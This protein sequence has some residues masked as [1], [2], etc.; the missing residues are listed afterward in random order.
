MTTMHPPDLA[1][2]EEHLLVEPTRARSARRLPPFVI[3]AAGLLVALIAGSIIAPHFLPN[4]SYVDLG[5]TL[6]GPGYHA[7]GGP[8][9]IL[10][11]DDLGRDEL[12]RALIGLRTSLEIALLA[13]L[14]GAAVGTALGMVAG[15]VG[16]VVDDLVM[17][18]VDIQMSVPGIL[19]IVTVVAIAKPG[20]LVIVIVLG[21]SVWM[22][23]ARVARAQILSLK[24]Q[25]MIL[26]I[27]SLGA[28][29]RRTL[30]RHVLP[31]IA[32]AL[33]VIGTLQIANLIIAEAALEYLGLGV[34][35]PTPTLGSMISTGQSV[36][37]TGAWWPVVVPGGAIVVVIVGITI[38]GDWVRDQMDPRVGAKR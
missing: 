34:P 15:Y 36:L 17:R 20:F 33:L 28:S 1:Q 6:R 7:T 9:H 26:A 4:P 37:T 27:R 2:L 32:P 22:V 10:G 5:A 14:V 11:T 23:F 31:N 38:L 19:L 25:D 18:F 8:L 35:A 30:M 13:T 12:S 29:N 24:E 3:A 16:G 21:V